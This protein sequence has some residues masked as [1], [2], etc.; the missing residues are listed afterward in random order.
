MGVG[1]RSG[2]FRAPVHF[3]HFHKSKRES[4]KWTERSTTTPWAASTATR[5]EFLRH[6]VV[7]PISVSVKTHQ[8][9]TPQPLCPKHKSPRLLALAQLMSI[10]PAPSRQP[11]LLQAPTLLKIQQTL[12]CATRTRT[13]SRRSLSN[14]ECTYSSCLFEQTLIFPQ[15]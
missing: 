9:Q 1:R 8:P 7:D 6:Q 13:P 5:P 4:K 15:F 10:Q 12:S 11:R 3:V 2:Y 14:P